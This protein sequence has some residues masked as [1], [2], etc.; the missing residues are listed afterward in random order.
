MREK[1]L[2]APAADYVSGSNPLRAD[3]LQ[4]PT[5]TFE[6]S[7]AQ[8]VF[9]VQSLGHIESSELKLRDLASQRSSVCKLGASQDSWLPSQVSHAKRAFNKIA[10]G[11]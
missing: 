10:S 7:Q 11:Y 5:F 2:R 8:S 4:Q 3:L 9:V 6:I 1:K